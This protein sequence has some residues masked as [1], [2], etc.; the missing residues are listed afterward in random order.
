MLRADCAEPK[1]KASFGLDLPSSSHL[2]ERERD[3]PG[4]RERERERDTHT[5]THTV[6]LQAF[7]QLL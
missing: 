6:I 2:V 7:A 1:I 5:H 4:R 3:L